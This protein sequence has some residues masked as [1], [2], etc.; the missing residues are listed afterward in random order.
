[1]A[2]LVIARRRQAGKRASIHRAQREEN[3]YFF[4]TREG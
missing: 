2:P 4:K 1:M 3:A